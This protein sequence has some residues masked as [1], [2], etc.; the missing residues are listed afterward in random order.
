MYII[1]MKGREGSWNQRRVASLGVLVWLLDVCVWESLS[2]ND[3]GMVGR[4]IC[5]GNNAGMS[6]YIVWIG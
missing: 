6:G 4:I 5:V 2:P 3:T 1:G